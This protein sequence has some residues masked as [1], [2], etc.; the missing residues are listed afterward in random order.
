[1]TDLERDAWA[2]LRSAAIFLGAMNFVFLGLDVLIGVLT[3]GDADQSSL[4]LAAAVGGIAMA[5]EPVLFEAVLVFFSKQEMRVSNSALASATATT[6]LVRVMAI[7]TQSTTTSSTSSDN[8][9]LMDFWNESPPCLHQVLEATLGVSSPPTQK[10]E[11]MLCG[12]SDQIGAIFDYNMVGSGCKWPEYPVDADL[13]YHRIY[14][15]NML[16]WMLTRQSCAVQRE[17]PN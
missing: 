17:L 2:R 13:I 5:C 14:N 15:T 10:D 6:M 8:A 3:E 11:Q 4:V 7:G 16:R 12:L 1:M 9:E